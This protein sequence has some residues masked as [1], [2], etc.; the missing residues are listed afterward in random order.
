MDPQVNNTT[1]TQTLNRAPN[2]V[3]TGWYVMALFGFLAGIAL[4]ILL[5][6]LIL[7]STDQGTIN[8]VQ[9]T[10]ILLLL[11]SPAVGVA[12]LVRD[13]ILRRRYRKEN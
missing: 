10:S 2:R 13:V 6:V 12:L 11:G 4:Y 8:I 9:F 7:T 5:F 3:P 1:P